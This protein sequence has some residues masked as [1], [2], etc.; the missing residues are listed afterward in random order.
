MAQ[1]VALPAPAGEAAPAS[2]RVAT[3][4]LRGT[5]VPIQCPTW[6]ITDHT[7]QS[8][9][10]IADVSHEGEPISLPV[11]R[12]GGPDEHVLRAR[13]CWWPFADDDRGPYLALEAGDDGECAELPPAAALAYADQITAHADHMR[14]MATD[15]QKEVA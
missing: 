10:F 5:E 9:L 14:R 12:F 11:P 4:I 13:L 3:A 15:L 2:S 7:T 1:T 8:V 6:C